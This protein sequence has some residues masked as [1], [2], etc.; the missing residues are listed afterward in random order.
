MSATLKQHL[1]DWAPR[2]GVRSARGLLR[3]VLALAIFGAPVCA[4]GDNAPPLI[5]KVEQSID[6]SHLAVDGRPAKELSGLGWDEDDQVLYAVSD[7]GVLFRFEFAGGNRSLARLELRSAVRLS[8]R[9]GS[10]LTRELA[11]AEGLSVRHGGNGVRG[12][13]EL[14]VAFETGSRIAAFATSGRLLGELAIPGAPIIGTQLRAGNRGLESVAEHPEL[15]LLTATEQSLQS[16]AKGLHTIRSSRGRSLTVTALNGGKGRLKAIEVLPNGQILLLERYKVPGGEQH[17]SVLRLLDPA[18][19]KQ[20]QLCETRDPAPDSARLPAGNF[21][22]LARLGPDLF[23]AV[24]DDFENGMRATR[25][26]LLRVD[27]MER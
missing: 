13:T 8:D 6:V 20:D 15:G 2:R 7:K 12:D 18:V 23:V 14:V 27:G 24:S 4:R 1:G 11:G 19:C 3:S 22:G 10:A 16:E 26:V 21:E 9:A 25:F 17:Q 5:V